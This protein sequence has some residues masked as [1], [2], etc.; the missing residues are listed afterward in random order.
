MSLNRDHQKAFS[1][2]V[3]FGNGAASSEHTA[4]KLGHWLFMYNELHYLFIK[5]KINLKKGGKKTIASDPFSERASAVIVGVRAQGGMKGERE[6]QRE[7]ES[8]GV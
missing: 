3:L 7:R 6:R 4:R 2:F 8:M 5:E 1:L